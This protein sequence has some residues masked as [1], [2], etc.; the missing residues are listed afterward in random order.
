MAIND[1]Q[2]DVFINETK[3]G[4]HDGSKADLVISDEMCMKPECVFYRKIALLH[5]EISELVESHR[6]NEIFKQCDKPIELDFASEEIADILIR[7]LTLAEFLNVNALTAGE[8][9]ANYNLSRP[10]KHGKKS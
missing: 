8:I 2:K 9:K 3:H 10:F 7:L 5:T 6:K 1:L 4:F